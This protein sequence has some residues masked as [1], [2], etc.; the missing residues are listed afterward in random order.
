[1]VLVNFIINNIQFLFFFL[2]GSFDNYGHAQSVHM[3]QKFIETKSFRVS[4]EV[5]LET[6]I[7]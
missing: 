4:Q 7:F 1:M 5:V 3:F 6:L 2:S